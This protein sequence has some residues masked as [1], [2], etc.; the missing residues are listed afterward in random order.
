MLIHALVHPEAAIGVEAQ[1]FLR[2]AHLVLAERSTV[3]LGGVHRVRRGIGDVRAD[4]D[5]GRT[6]RFRAG[7]LEG[8]LQRLQVLRVGHLLHVPAVGA[9][10]RG[11]VLGVEGDRGGAVDRDVVVVVAHDQLAQ[12]EV[13]GDGGRL[14]ADALHH[15]P[16]RADRVRMV[17]HHRASGAVEALGEEALGDRHADGVA[18]ALAERTGRDLDPGRVPPLGVAGSARAPLTELPEVL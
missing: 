7:G 15:V 2:R 16:V 13:P 8:I 9:H 1:R 12:A 5:E 4:R 14:L 3:R 11:V 18:H 6:L 10:A 17:V